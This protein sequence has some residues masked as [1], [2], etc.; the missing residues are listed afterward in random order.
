MANPASAWRRRSLITFQNEMKTI[1]ITL[2]TTAVY[3][4][5]LFFPGSVVDRLRKILTEQKD[6]RLVFIVPPKDL[7]KYEALFAGDIGECWRIEP[8][9]VSYPHT[10]LQKFFYFFYSY[11]IYTGT[12]WQLATLGVRPD[13]PPAGG[14]FKRYLAPLKYGIAH[15]FGR[16]RFMREK[17]VPFLYLRIF[18]ERPFLTLFERYRPDL[19]FV[20]HIYGRMDTELLAEAKRRGVKT[21]GMASN[22][23]HYDK[24]Y[25]PFKADK[26]LVQS[27]QMKD[28]AARYQGYDP[29]RLVLVGY[30]YFDFIA[31]PAY[32]RSREDTL[33]ILDFPPTARYILYVSGSSYCPDEP[34][35]IE[36]IL[37]WAEEGRFGEDVR[38][39]I[40]PYLGGRAK[41]REFDEEKYNRFE[42]HPLVAFYRKEFWGD[43]E[44]SI[45]FMNIV[46]HSA[47]I[48]SIYSTIVIEAAV[49]DR[50]LVGIG[51]DGYKKRPLQKSINRFAK[52][53]HFRDVL[54][55]GGLRTAR[56]FEELFSILDSYFKNPSLD[57]EGRERLRR[58]VCHAL[59]G[60]SSERIVEEMLDFLTHPG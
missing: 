26:L 4:N 38:L 45:Q 54:E 30:P 47:S 59:D 60:R 3:R 8:I 51:F 11:F 46:R 17:F 53:E 21:I 13:E 42:K 14:R 41:D 22:W 7:H 44:K 9:A 49:L 58:R 23:D 34:D 6:L 33:H 31:N 50:P 37:R 36:A 12:T 35:I 29:Q 48:I 15:T 27:E 5:L 20:S 57:A 24:Y 10:F 40:R 19:V 2:S 1:L 28:F 25:L 43:M 16:S 32:A 18:R 52:R 56:S 39:V 55:S